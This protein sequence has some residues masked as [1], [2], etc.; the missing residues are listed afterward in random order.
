VCSF[1]IKK[2]TYVCKKFISYLF[3]LICKKMNDLSGMK[4]INLSKADGVELTDKKMNALKGAGICWGNPVKRNSKK[5]AC[6]AYGCRRAAI[7]SMDDFGGA[8]E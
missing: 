3:N 8:V 4:L 2:S 7:T 6:P 1:K 5:N